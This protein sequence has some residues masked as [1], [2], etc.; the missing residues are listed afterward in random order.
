[1]ETRDTLLLWKYGVVQRVSLLVFALGLVELLLFMYQAISKSEKQ[2]E[3]KFLNNSKQKV[4][5][6]R[7]P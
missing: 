7:W 2:E 5:G 4:D 1:M 6:G 3:S